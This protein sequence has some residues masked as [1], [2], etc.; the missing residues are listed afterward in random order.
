MN[1]R[2]AVLDKFDGHCAYCGKEI[3]LKEMQVDHFIPKQLG[4]T[5]KFENLLPACRRCNFYKQDHLLH[6]FRDLLT[7]LSDRLLG[8]FQVKIASDYGIVVIAKWDGIFYF[9]KIQ[10]KQLTKDDVLGTWQDEM[11]LTKVKKETK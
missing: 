2:Q 3:T 5:A 1:N 11:A 7:T 10:N 4:G 8:M 6:D 9:E